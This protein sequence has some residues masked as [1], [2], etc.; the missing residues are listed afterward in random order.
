MRVM[1]F[2]GLI[3]SELSYADSCQ[4]PLLLRRAYN[5]AIKIALCRYEYQGKRDGHD[6][7]VHKRLHAR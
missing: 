3:D 1:P 5:N 4:A 7:I 6:H 2:D